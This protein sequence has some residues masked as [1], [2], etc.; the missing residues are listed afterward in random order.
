MKKI[1]M[2]LVLIL[3]VISVTSCNNTT[4]NNQTDIGNGSSET[5]S[6]LSTDEPQ[7]EKESV[8]LGNVDS[9]SY[10]HLSDFYL[11]V[12]HYEQD[13]SKYIEG[14]LGINSKIPYYR[15]I[16]YLVKLEQLFPDLNLGDVK[17]KYVWVTSPNEYIYTFDNDMEIKVKTSP[18]L[19]DFW[20][21]TPGAMVLHDY[22]ENV[23]C[24]L[25]A[26]FETPLYVLIRIPTIAHDS[27]KNSSSTE[28][29][30]LLSDDNNVVREQL[31]IIAKRFQDMN[32]K[33]YETNYIYS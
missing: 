29:K 27:I 1:T 14:A 18:Y 12:E 16:Q 6:T 10:T 17:L 5:S 30:N 11:Y 22:E 3:L 33:R 21:S 23:I 2:F 7:T 28:L 13:A 4:T 19:R 31:D 24:E 32:L 15:Q 26:T 20:W 9:F 25:K 8:I